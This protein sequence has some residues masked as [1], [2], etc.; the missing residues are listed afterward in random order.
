MI[1]ASSPLLFG[2]MYDYLNCVKQKRNK[3]GC[4][5]PLNFGDGVDPLI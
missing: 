5:V 1:G 2:K 3:R 4:L